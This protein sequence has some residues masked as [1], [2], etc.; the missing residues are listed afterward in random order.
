MNATALAG[1]ML[2]LPQR[3]TCVAERACLPTLLACLESYC[4]RHGV[5]PQVRHDLHLIAEEA[6]VNVIAYAYPEGA[7]GPLTLQVEATRAGGRPAMEMTIE[8][9]GMPFN[10]LALP[11]PDQSAPLADLPIG[12]LG[13]HLIRRLS[14]MQH[15]RHDRERGNVLTITKLL[16]PPRQD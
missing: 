2:G 5:D 1:P 9:R 10:P 4:A 14:D 11:A 13:V 15:Y 3:T 7:P 16:V 6:C 12:G 8:D